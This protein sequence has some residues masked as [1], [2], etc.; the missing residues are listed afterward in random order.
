MRARHFSL[1]IFP[2]KKHRKG[3][4]PFQ[5]K[6]QSTLK[7]LCRGT[8]NR[9]DVA[10]HAPSSRASVRSAARDNMVSTCGANQQTLSRAAA[11]RNRYPALP[12]SQQLDNRNEFNMF[13]IVMYVVS[14]TRT[15]IK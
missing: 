12:E 6:E 2:Q 3:T 13:T 8:K 14:K 15:V 9:S 5:L 10:R 7:S 11:V 1:Y 4:R